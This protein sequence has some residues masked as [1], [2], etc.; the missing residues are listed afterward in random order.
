VKCCLPH[1]ENEHQQRFNDFWSCIFG[2]MSGTLLQIS[3]NKDM[4]ACIC[5]Y[6][7]DISATSSRTVTTYFIYRATTKYTWAFS[8]ENTVKTVYIDNNGHI[9]LWLT[10]MQGHQSLLLYWLSFSRWGREGFAFPCTYKGGHFFVSDCI[11]PVTPKIAKDWPPII[12]DT[13]LIHTIK[14]G[15]TGYSNRTCLWRQPTIGI[16]LSAT[17][18]RSSYLGQKTKNHWLSIDNYSQ[19]GIENASL[20]VLLIKA[21]N[22]SIRYKCDQINFWWPHLQDRKLLNLRWH[23]FSR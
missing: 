15:Q 21:A 11:Q 12:I 14:M 10:M 19:D 13:P 17:S 20:E 9:E 16:L 2:S 8:V 6:V 7:Q 23:S 4:E 1:L 5:R 18:W 22:P 3:T